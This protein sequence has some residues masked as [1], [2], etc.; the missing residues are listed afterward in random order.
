MLAYVCW[1]WG[2]AS[3]ALLSIAHDTDGTRIGVKGSGTTRLAVV[4][5]NSFT[6][7]DAPKLMTAVV[8]GQVDL[9]GI[10]N[11][12]TG[13]PKVAS[14]I[15]FDL[16]RHKYH[17]EVEE[18]HDVLLASPRRFIRLRAGFLVFQ[19]DLERRILVDGSGSISDAHRPR[20][21][22]EIAAYEYMQA[23]YQTVDPDYIFFEFDSKSTPSIVYPAYMKEVVTAKG[24]LSDSRIK[25]VDLRLP[26]ASQ[27]MRHNS[28]RDAILEY[29]WWIIATIL[30]AISFLMLIIIYRRGAG[31]TNGRS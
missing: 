21:I 31:E 18:K 13:N 7:E 20:E 25:S 26:S 2:F 17:A 5:M 3:L 19:T 9:L 16:Q 11:Y 28:V 1:L 8:E 14:R 12:S 22:L 4:D 30:L 29:F 15:G 6:L 27:V 10:L 23:Q 24:N